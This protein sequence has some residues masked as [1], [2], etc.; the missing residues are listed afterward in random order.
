MQT[1]VVVL[2]VIQSINQ[3]NF[4]I[5]LKIV[6]DFLFIGELKNEQKVIANT[7]GLWTAFCS[8]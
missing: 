1:T 5:H 3:G 7:A 4:S 2:D 6:I 8:V